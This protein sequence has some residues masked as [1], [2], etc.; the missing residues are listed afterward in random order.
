MIDLTGR[1]ILIVDDEAFIREHVVKHLLRM[2]AE[3][4]QACN[5]Q[6]ALERVA[7]RRPDVILMDV[8]MPV[9]DGFE[10]TKALKS[11]PETADIPIIILSAKAQECERAIGIENGADSY[12]TKPARFPSIVAELEKYLTGLNAPVG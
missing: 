2:G 7:Q 11:K 8:R 3:V 6:Q 1:T 9:M 12:L 4:I 10:A 5:G